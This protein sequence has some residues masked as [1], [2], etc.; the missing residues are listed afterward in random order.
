MLAKSHLTLSLFFSCA[1][2]VLTALAAE[3]AA[4]APSSEKGPRCSDGIDNDGDGLID[5]ADPDCGGV[6]ATYWIAIPWLVPVLSGQS[7]GELVF[8]GQ[9]VFLCTALTMVVYRQRVLAYRARQSA[10]EAL[11]EL[12][13]AQAA[14]LRL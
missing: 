8:V 5:D 10:R 12:R 1:L 2:V 3:P 4:A 13:S 7:G 14:P 11:D 6:A 9:V